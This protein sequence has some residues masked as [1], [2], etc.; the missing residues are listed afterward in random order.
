VVGFFTY[1]ASTGWI[2]GLDI[3]SRARDMFSLVHVGLVRSWVR[4]VSGAG[5]IRLTIFSFTCC[6][7]LRCCWL[8]CRTLCLESIQCMSKCPHR[9]FPHQQAHRCM[10][11]L[12]PR[13]PD[14]IQPEGYIASI[15]WI[16]DRLLIHD[17]I[18]VNRSYPNIFTKAV[19]TPI[20]PTDILAI[21][22][23]FSHTYITPEKRS[24]FTVVAR[25]VNNS[26]G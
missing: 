12:L 6:D 24:I 3:F 10:P 23:I 25:A 17:V 14:Q 16:D 19:Y 7:S 26:V 2:W 15:N 20:S 22:L 13:T 4:C 5:S 18:H 9:R 8:L 11:I 21:S 1:F